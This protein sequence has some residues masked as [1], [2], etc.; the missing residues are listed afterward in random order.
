M[1]GGACWYAT[2]ATREPNEQRPLGRGGAVDTVGQRHDIGD[3][4]IRD[5][6]HDERIALV[7]L[8]EL[9]VESDANVSEGE[10]DE[11]AA[12]ADE[13]GAEEY[14]A[15]AAEVDRRFADEDALKTFLRTISRQEAR[16][17]IYGAA[18]EAAL[19]E[20]VGVRESE[21]LD[22]LAAEWK[23]SVVVANP[24]SDDD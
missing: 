14:R 12:V 7:A 21:A 3:V 22:W 1:G 11:I 23:V 6:T 16:E 15:L 5:L 19:P 8:L 20:A 18:L 9:V 17:V 2:R 24:T 4:E 10:L 13:L